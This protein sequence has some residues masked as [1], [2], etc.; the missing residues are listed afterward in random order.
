M[1]SAPSSRAFAAVFGRVGVRADPQPAQA[2][3]PLEHRLEVLVD[4]RR[5]ERHAPEDD[6][7][8]AAVDRQQVAF[9]ELV[10]VDGGDPRVHVNG[11]PLAAGHARLAHPPRDDG[12]VRGHPAV[13]GEHTLRLEQ[14]V[15][16]VGSRLPADED[17][18]LARLA[19]LLR[20]A[21]VE[22]DLARGGA[23]RRVEPGGDHLD[24]CLRVDH[25]VQ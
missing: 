3:G 7:A 20:A 12:G 19:E 11:Q 5:N 13:R 4:L 6:A 16:V 25:R 24:G 22:H 18:R 10:A 9:R 1:P 23:G 14:A 15:D 2:V 21:G 8:G 17:H